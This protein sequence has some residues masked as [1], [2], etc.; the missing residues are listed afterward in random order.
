MTRSGTR[1]APL[2]IDMSTSKAKNFREHQRRKRKGVQR[3]LLLSALL[4][5]RA[6]AQ[7]TT[8]PPA[9]PFPA[10]APGASHAD[11]DLRVA[12]PNPDGWLFPI[13]QLGRVHTIK[14]IEW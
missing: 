6:V 9:D 10:D 4:L 5:G 13:T 3:I 14:T 11:A 2:T 12:G 8:P 1:V 7:Q